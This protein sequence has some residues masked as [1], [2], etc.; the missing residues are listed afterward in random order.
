[1]KIA[2]F[3]ESD[4]DPV[5]EIEN[6]SFRQPWRR[7]SFLEELSCKNSLNLVV[8]GGESPPREEVIAYL[9]SRLI[10]K[11]M[12]ILKIAVAGRWRRHGIASLLLKES[13]Q[14]ACEENTASAVLDVRLSNRPAIC[15]YKKHGFQTAGI[16]PNYY[17]DTGEAALV[18]RKNLKE[19]L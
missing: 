14:A 1:M 4:I 5:L 15:L 6:H 19:D 2:G 7:I 8:Q 10:E 9:C 16:R 13:F 3:S 11:E 12:Y 17:S 18:M